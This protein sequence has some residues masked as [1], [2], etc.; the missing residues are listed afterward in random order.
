MPRRIKILAHLVGRT[1]SAV[2]NVA[3]AVCER[4]DETPG[5]RGE[6]M[7]LTIA[8]CVQPQDLPRRTL[9]HKRVQHRQ[10]RRHADPRAQQHHRLLSRLKYETSTRCADVESIAHLD[11]LSQVGASNSIRFDLYADSKMIGRGRA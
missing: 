9:R 5:F 3:V 10:N 1:G 7:M 2:T 8:S 6:G 4:R 11:M